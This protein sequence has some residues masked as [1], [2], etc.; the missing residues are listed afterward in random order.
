M[1]RWIDFPPY[2]MCL[3]NVNYLLIIKSLFTPF[4]SVRCPLHIFHVY[5]RQYFITVE[6]YA[7]KHMIRLSVDFRQDST[8][9]I[10]LRKSLVGANH[11]T[12]IISETKCLLFIFIYF[13]SFQL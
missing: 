9:L 6:C 3:A 7:P 2:M 4:V 13:M 11:L 10:Q 5:C 1:H 8:I 12:S